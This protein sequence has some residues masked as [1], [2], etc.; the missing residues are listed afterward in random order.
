MR[1]QDLIECSGYI[2]QTAAEAKDP[3][4]SRA[5]SVDVDIHTM[6][7]QYKKLFGPFTEQELQEQGCKY[8]QYWCST[9]KVYKCR[10]TPK[11][12]RTSK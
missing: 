1:L 7:E 4:F 2:P 6:D 11:K 9:D 12:T 8:G 5:L 10:Q 3:R